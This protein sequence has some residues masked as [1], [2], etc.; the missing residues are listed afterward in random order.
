[1]IQQL[2]HAAGF[3]EDDS[4]DRRLDRLEKLLARATEKI[5]ES[6]PLIALDG[7]SRYG[8]LTLTP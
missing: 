1:V 8:A 3:A 4:S 5:D 7:T 6:A 2:V